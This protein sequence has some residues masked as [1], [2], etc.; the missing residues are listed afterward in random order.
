MHACRAWAWAWAYTW[1]QA[2]GCTAA[3]RKMPA[4]SRTEARVIAGY[5]GPGSPKG[6]GQRQGRLGLFGLSAASGGRGTAASLVPPP[7]PEPPALQLP[8]GE[9][10]SSA[11]A[12]ADHASA[13]CLMRRAA[14]APVTGTKASAAAASRP[15][16]LVPLLPHSPRATCRAVLQLGLAWLPVHAQSRLVMAVWLTTQL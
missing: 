12:D 6:L 5:S 8:T 7:C 10:G 14:A 16:P 11:D 2:R 15:R 1:A 9:L 13:V 4:L 3:G